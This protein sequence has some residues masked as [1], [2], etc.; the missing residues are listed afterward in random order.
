MPLIPPDAPLTD[1]EAIAATQ[2][3][4]E[5]EVSASRLNG[6]PQYDW[7]LPRDRWSAEGRAG[8]RWRRWVGREHCPSG[9]VLG[10]YGPAEP[11]G[12]N[13]I[14][15]HRAVV[16]LVF[17][18][19]VDLAELPGFGFRVLPVVERVREGKAPHSVYEAWCDRLPRES[20]IVARHW[21]DLILSLLRLPAR[22]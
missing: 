11:D 15:W 12:T 1:A 2:A 13:A 19:R 5:Q 20:S 9:W 16:S 3:L 7:T 8:F 21:G 6:L 10:E 17:P 4:P 22:P 14:L 18:M